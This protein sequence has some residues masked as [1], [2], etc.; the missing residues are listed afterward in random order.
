MS[1]KIIIIGAGIAG[2]TA[3]IYAKRSGFDV[4][5][6]EKHS[7]TGGMCTAWKRKGYLFEGA[8]HWLT[9]SS[10]KTEVNKIWRDT[11]ALDDSVPI[12]LHDHFNS[13]ECN[14]KTIY[15]YRDIEKTAKHLLSI[16][17]EDAAHIRQL[18]KD[19]KSLSKMQMPIIDIK[20]VKAA[21][22]KAMSLGFMFKMLPA[23]PKMNRLGKLS[24]HEYIMRF[25]HPGIRRL[26]RIVPDEYQARSFIFTL[27]TLNNGDGGYPE[28]GSLAMV[29]RM[30]KTFTDLGGSL[31]LNTQVQE[32]NIENGT[33]VGITLNDKIL[34]ADA[35]IVTQETISAINQLFS[36][37]LDDPWIAVLREN[38][39]STICTFISIGVRAEMP[40][41][42]VPEWKLSTPIT[43]AGKTLEYLS[44]NSYAGEGYAPKGGTAITTAFLDDTYDFWKN[45]K[46]KGIYEE[47]KQAL[48]KQISQALCEKYP[49]AAGNID[50]IDIATPLTYERYTGAHRGSWMT[51]IG[52][53]DKMKPYPTTAKDVRGLYFA[54]HRLIPPGGLPAAALSGRNAAQYVCRQFNVEFH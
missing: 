32:V 19:I 35:I 50:V 11:G 17:P 39:K 44:F 53:G 38:T 33:A 34:T 13:V 24:C 7:I 28:G 9:G 21:N 40:E 31:L 23:L 30:E 16:A 20:G 1:K 49:Q 12:F 42:T 15:L 36:K 37:P 51:A 54:G 6:I 4:T 26:L 2:L 52:V 45:A 8:M 3:G 27:S 5:L 43:Y 47:E 29:K 46:D 22:P 41:T 18:V 25:S 48:A 14:G 10:P